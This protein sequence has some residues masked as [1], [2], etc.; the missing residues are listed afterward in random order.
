MGQWYV[1]SYFYYILI[2]PCFLWLLMVSVD[3]GQWALVS[4]LLYNVCVIQFVPTTFTS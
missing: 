2:F 3:L 1:H 4:F